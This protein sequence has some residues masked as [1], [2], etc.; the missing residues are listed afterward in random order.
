MEPMRRQTL[1][2]RVRAHLGGSEAPHVIHRT[3]P[4]Y[5]AGDVAIAIK[6]YLNGLAATLAP[7]LNLLGEVDPIF[8]Y[9]S[10]KYENEVNLFDR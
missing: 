3:F 10:T 1:N 4:E 2:G 7:D 9:F 6:E 8:Q 5:L